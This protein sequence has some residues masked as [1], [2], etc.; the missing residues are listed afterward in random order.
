[1][2][3]IERRSFVEIAIFGLNALMAA[4][5]GIPA[6]AYL[7][8]R[9]PPARSVDWVEVARLEDIRAGEP[10]EILFERKRVD[11]WKTLHERSSVWVLKD[12]QGQV[13][14]LAPGCTHLGCAYHWEA[15]RRQFVC[16]CHTSTFAPDGAVTS[17]PAPRALDR[18]V[19][20][21]ENG[22]LK[23]G[24]VRRSDG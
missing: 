5:L 12:D 11:G 7:F 9:K 15:A 19:T 17:G 2:K 10:R 3:K 18:Y 6:I 8:G 1:M 16:P 23:I 22:K 21:I 13:I 4:A 14:A 20:R 24:E